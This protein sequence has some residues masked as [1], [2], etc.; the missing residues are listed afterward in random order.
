MKTSTVIAILVSVL[1]SFASVAAA[2]GYLWS[3]G[4]PGD[5]SATP[6]LPTVWPT[7][8][9]VPLRSVPLPSGELVTALPPDS[10]GQVLCQALPPE[11]WNQILG[12]AALRE[13]RGQSCHVVT[14]TLEISLTLD[15]TVGTLNPTRTADIA[16][17]PGQLEFLAPKANARLGVRLVGAAANDE[18]RPYLLANL[19]ATAA[20][21]RNPPDTLITTVARE[22]VAATMAP[23]PP[24][25]PV[26]PGG[27]IP[28]RKAD[29]V[30]GHGIVD[31]PWP[32]ISWQLCT[33]LSRE[34]GGTPKPEFGGRCTVGGVRAA[35]TDTVS[36]RVY[37]GTLAGR[38]ALITDDLVAIKLTDDSA[39]E[40]TFSGGGS[41]RTLA[42]KV[43]PA[44]VSG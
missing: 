37:P 29:P 36:P 35:Y 19:T 39:Q 1:L 43:A 33:S 44:L 27:A 42:E 25:P 16:G 18:I 8:E 14:A 40:L 28:P 13:V 20:D 31:S 34:L 9:G 7:K 41:L 21:P 22:V 23:G 3:R 30:H 32:M 12:G 38:P 11:R 2:T 17:H 10:I 6:A 5:R 15:R 24:L 26:G 4:G